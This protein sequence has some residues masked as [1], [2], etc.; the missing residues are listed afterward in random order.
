MLLDAVKVIDADEI[1]LEG[2]DDGTLLTLNSS[3]DKFEFR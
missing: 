3:S 2:K 1:E